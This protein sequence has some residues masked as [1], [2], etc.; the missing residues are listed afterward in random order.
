MSTRH[1]MADDRS[2]AIPR[3]LRRALRANAGFSALSGLAIAGFSGSLPDVMGAGPSL[4]YL[5]LGIG[6]AAYA[7][8]LFLLSRRD[9][10][11]RLEAVLVVAGDVAWVAGSAVVL[12]AGVLTAQGAALVAGA[13]AVVA[14]LAVWQGRNL[15]TSP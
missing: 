13:A 6:L 11:R 3:A 14:A 12:V 8:H 10:L 5:V 7:A 4:L 2:D 15:P 9:E 1:V